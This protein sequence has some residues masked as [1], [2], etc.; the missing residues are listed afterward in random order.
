MNT[1][2]YENRK[3]ISPAQ[4]AAL[5]DASGI[6]RPTGDLA[7]MEKMLKHADVLIT[8][9]DE[10]RLVGVARALTDFSYCCYLSDLAVDKRHQHTGIGG[11]LIRHV[12][13]AIGEETMLLLLAAPEAMNYYP[14]VGF[15]AVGNG[16]IIKRTR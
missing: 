16:W 10:D 8:A 12:R 9:W 4:L 3:P 2:R 11:E 13:A 5:F 1:I 6:R 15:E 7:R 14:K